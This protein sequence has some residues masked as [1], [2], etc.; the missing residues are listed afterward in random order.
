M[1]TVPVGDG[2]DE[3]PGVVLRWEGWRDDVPGFL[4]AGVT[5]PEVP[6]GDLPG[7]E[8]AFAAGCAEP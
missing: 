7:S 5:G 2:E 1:S 3:G 8:E 6:G 4:C